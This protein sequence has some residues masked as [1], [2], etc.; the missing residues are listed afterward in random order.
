MASI[1]AYPTLV[2]NVAQVVQ[3][4]DRYEFV[5]IVNP[6]AGI[7]YFLDGFFLFF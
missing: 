1:S 4:N 6:G 5:E 3:L 7:V 2:A